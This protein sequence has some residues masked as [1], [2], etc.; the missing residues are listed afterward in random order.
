M[1]GHDLLSV[2]TR[3]YEQ[4]DERVRRELVS[5]SH[6]DRIIRCGCFK[7]EVKATLTA[8]GGRVTQPNH[9]N[10]SLNKMTSSRPRGHMISNQQYKEQ[11]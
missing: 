8:G 9:L 1:R 7:G 6:L 10:S 4:V 3:G 11:I 2:R 5:C